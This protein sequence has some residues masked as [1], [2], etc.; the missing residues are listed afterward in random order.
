MQVGGLWRPEKGPILWTRVP[1]SCEG[2]KMSAGNRTQIPCK[3]NKHSQ[4]LSHHCSSY[5]LYHFDL[6]SRRPFL[7]LPSFCK[8]ASHLQFLY[9]SFFRIVDGLRSQVAPW[10]YYNL[11]INSIKICLYQ[12]TGSCMER[13][14][15][16]RGKQP[17]D[18]TANVFN[19]AH[20]LGF[21]FEKIFEPLTRPL[22]FSLGSQRYFCIYTLVIG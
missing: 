17:R 3:P 21:L 4:Q 1:G 6:I 22:L 19:S 16:E 5:W 11:V 2:A 9:L 14:K 13:Y 15:S 20:F 7:C 12:N 8:Q 10:V 18:H